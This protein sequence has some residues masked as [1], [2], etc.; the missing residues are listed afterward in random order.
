METAETANRNRATRRK[1]FLDK[2]NHLSLK[3]TQQRI[4]ARTAI[5]G[6]AILTNQR[7]IGKEIAAHRVGG[8][9]GRTHPRARL[10]LS[11]VLRSSSFASNLGEV[12]DCKERGSNGNSLC[13]SPHRSNARSSR[14]RLFIPHPRFLAPNN[15]YSRHILISP[16]RDTECQTK[17]GSRHSKTAEK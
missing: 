2:T 11:V 15:L 12:N 17:S 8:L 14:R 7:V 3:V 10:P 13:R 4:P 16:D 5:C 9:I 6:A 1:I